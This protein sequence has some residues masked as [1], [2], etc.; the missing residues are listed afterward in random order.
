M[1]E[2]VIFSFKDI[3]PAILSYC[4]FRVDEYT[5]EIAIFVEY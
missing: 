3:G 1:K 5:I 2:I 4:I